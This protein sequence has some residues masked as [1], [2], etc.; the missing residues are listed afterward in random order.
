MNA[1]PVIAIFD[2]GKTNKKFFLINEQYKIIHE[3]SVQFNA[4]LDE[5]GD[6]CEDLQALT[7]WIHQT[8]TELLAMGQFNI[9]ALNFSA[10]GASLVH[11]GTDGVPVTPLYDYL[12]PFPEQLKK[13]FYKS[14]GGETAFSIST[15]SPVLGNLN[16]GMQLYRLKE[17]RKEL[18]NRIHYSLHL[19]QYAGYLITGKAYSDMTSIGCHTGLWDFGNNCYHHWVHAENILAKLAPI[20]SSDKVTDVTINGKKIAVGAGL[21]DS[22]AALIPYLACFSEPFVLISTGTWCISLNPFNHDPLTAEELQQ[23]CLCYKDY[24]GKPVKASRLFA[25]NEHER[26]LPVLA[27]HFGVPVDTYHEVVFNSSLLSTLV[28]DD[29]APGTGSASSAF[30]KRQ[31]DSFDSY[32]KAYHQLLYD[33]IQQ[34][35]VSTSLVINNAKVKKIFVDG[36]FAKNPVYMHLL[37]EAFPA[38]EVFAA[39]M[40]QATA[41]GAALAIHVHWNT[42]PVP[43]S[44]VALKKY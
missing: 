35:Q 22:S 5:D 9:K 24:N 30:G 8:L 42:G 13:K 19:P 28:V 33:I 23:D 31:L 38:M 37:A 18:F 27:D 1:T 17:Q 15:A 29:I 40:S 41:L 25:G 20:F 6:A 7:A 43:D 16:S 36:G 39:S 21:H 32:E 2:I 10:Y 11:I 26:Q 34:Q 14:Y 4:V 3:G 12:K 44:M